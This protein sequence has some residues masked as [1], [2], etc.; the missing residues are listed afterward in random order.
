MFG[1]F[2]KTG[3]VAGL[4]LAIAF[5]P[6]TA[7]VDSGTGTHKEEYPGSSKAASSGGSTEAVGTQPEEYG[8]PPKPKVA[9]APKKTPSLPPGKVTGTPGSPERVRASGAKAPPPPPREAVNKTSTGRERTGPGAQPGEYN[10][11]GGGKKVGAY[12][13][14][15]NVRI[16]R[17]TPHP[18]SG[19]RRMP[20]RPRDSSR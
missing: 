6:A 11:A 12:D 13:T 15:H 9:P 20:P 1:S 19:T 7:A 18:D 8:S 5:L 16:R 10:A 4:L 14:V 2:M 17:D 3:G